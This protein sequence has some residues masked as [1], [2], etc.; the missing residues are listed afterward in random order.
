MKKFVYPMQSILNIKMKLEDQEKTN[1]GLAKMRLNEEEQKLE[2]LTRRLVQY[3]ERKRQSM[4]AALRLF[5]IR[6]YEEA[7]KTLKIMIKSQ[8]K[9][10]EIARQ[11]ADIGLA[12]LNRAVA[13]RKTQELLKDRA[14]EVYKAEMEAEEQKEIDELV[15]FKYSLEAKE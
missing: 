8:M 5:E 6:Q 14:F 10:V 12:K 2:E 11:T 15:S 3:E 7:I 9:A 4:M 13:E 1:Y